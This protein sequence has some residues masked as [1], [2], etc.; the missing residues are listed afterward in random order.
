VAET[1]VA[2]FFPRDVGFTHVVM[3]RKAAYNW[4]PRGFFFGEEDAQI[5]AD[6]AEACGE[7]RGS[8]DDTHPTAEDA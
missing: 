3:Y 4:V 2:W 6:A 5:Y 7:H 8:D 1:G